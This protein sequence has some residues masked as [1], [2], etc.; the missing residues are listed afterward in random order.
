MSEFVYQDIREKIRIAQKSLFEDLKNIHQTPKLIKAV[1]NINLGELGKNEKILANTIQHIRTITLQHPA[2]IKSVKDLPDFKI[3]K[4]DLIGLK[5]T[6]RKE[7]LLLFLERLIYL[8]IPRLKDFKGFSSLT[9]S[10]KGG[11]TIGFNSLNVF[12]EISEDGINSS[13][14]CSINIYIK[15]RGKIDA[16]QYMKSLGFPVKL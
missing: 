7:K 1:V 10:E 5:V 6:L 14:G 13:V 3:K 11:F 9:F 15:S 4:G 16:I 12:P 2:Y 8:Y